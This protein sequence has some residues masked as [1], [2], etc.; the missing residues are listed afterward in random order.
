MTEKLYRFKAKIYAADVGKGGA[1]L[2]F[3]YDVREEFGR[4][5][6]KVYATYD[7]VVYEGSLVNM[8]V[9]HPDGSICYIIGIPKKIRAK[10]KKEVGDEVTVTI[11]ERGV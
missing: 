9:K 5:R 8:G 7:E 11:K 2:K 1:Y 6:V 3:P 10:I 4:G